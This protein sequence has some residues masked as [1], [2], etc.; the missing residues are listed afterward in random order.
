MG[1]EQKQASVDSMTAYA[2]IADLL[3]FSSRVFPPFPIEQIGSLR[4]CLGHIPECSGVQS[5][6][7]QNVADQEFLLGRDALLFRLWREAFG[8][9]H[10]GRRRCWA[11]SRDWVRHSHQFSANQSMHHGAC[12]NGGMPMRPM[13]RMCSARRGCSRQAAELPEQL[14]PSLVLCGAHGRTSWSRPMVLPVGPTLR[15]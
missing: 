5:K 13:H 11:T 15:N 10:N 9:R 8:L 1:H 2:R 3:H 7:M 6:W 12:L 14:S 4:R